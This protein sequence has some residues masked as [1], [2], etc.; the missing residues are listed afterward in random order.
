MFDSSSPAPRFLRRRR[1]DG[2]RRGEL[3]Y[4]SLASPLMGLFKKKLGEPPVP[5]EAV[6][7]L[8]AG[9]ITIRYEEARMGRSVGD[10]T[11]KPW[12]GIPAGLDITVRATAGGDPL[13]IRRSM[14]SQEYTTLKAVGSKYG[15]VEVATAGD[16]T[17]TVAPF[18]AERELFEP[19]LSVKG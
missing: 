6:V 17:F 4:L 10:D 15:Y 8:P 16:Y 12:P 1:V 19:H 2:R 18:T 9:K 7:S 13:A 14:G 5:G 11:G 3:G